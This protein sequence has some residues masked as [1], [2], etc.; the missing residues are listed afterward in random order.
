MEGQCGVWQLLEDR[1][2]MHV[3]ATWKETCDT[4]VQE[5]D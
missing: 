3:E 5:Q 1:W 4:Y 2:D